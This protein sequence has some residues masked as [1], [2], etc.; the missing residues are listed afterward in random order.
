MG[1]LGEEIYLDILYLVGGEVFVR[2]RIDSPLCVAA[3]VDVAVSV[4]LAEKRGMAAGQLHLHAFGNDQFGAER[5]GV[6]FAVGSLDERRH[7]AEDRAVLQIEH[8]P[9]GRRLKK[10][11]LS[12]E[13]PEVT[14]PERAELAARP[15]VELHF[16]SPDR[17][18][19]EYDMDSVNHPRKV[20][21]TQGIIAGTAELGSGIACFLQISLDEIWLEAL[22]EVYL[23]A[24]YFE[25]FSYFV[26]HLLSICGT[27]FSGPSLRGPI[28]GKGPKKTPAAHLITSV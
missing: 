8:C 21:R 7:P 20:L 10:L 23:I 15:G 18:S 26:I 11:L 3:V 5:K 9:G 16:V 2:Q 25:I 28:P 13:Q 22:V 19:V 6:F 27:C 4:E 14:Y 24:A 12:P 17:Q 1:D